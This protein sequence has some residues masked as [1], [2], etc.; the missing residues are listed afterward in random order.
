MKSSNKVMLPIRRKVVVRSSKPVVRKKTPPPAVDP[1]Q[2]ERIKYL[3][4]VAHT[5]ET[6]EKMK[7]KRMPTPAAV[8][9]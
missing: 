1:E 4:D 7:K 8:K 2:L 3:G 6:I 9:K 5:L